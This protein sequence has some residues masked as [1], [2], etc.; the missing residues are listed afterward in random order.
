LPD[1][2]QKEISSILADL[3]VIEY[4]HENMNRLIKLM[5]IEL[6]RPTDSAEEKKRKEAQI[7]LSEDSL[8]LHQNR[9]TEVLQLLT[10]K[11]KVLNRKQSRVGGVTETGPVRTQSGRILHVV[12]RL[13][14][15]TMCDLNESS[16]KLT[17]TELILTKYPMHRAQPTV[18]RR[19]HPINIEPISLSPRP[20]FC[21]RFVAGIMETT[22]RELEADV[23]N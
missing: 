8:L 17:T 3:H 16:K 5:M 18:P 13:W 14:I 11:L 4:A 9:C 15:K 1:A 12:W 2:V 23:A 20:K 7:A 21:G 10:P 19:F 6:P 22:V